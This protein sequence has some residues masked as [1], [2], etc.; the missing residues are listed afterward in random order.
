M[1][2]TKDKFFIIGKRGRIN[3][4]V[5][6]LREFINIF[7]NIKSIINN[8]QVNKKEIF[9]LNIENLNDENVLF[10]EIINSKSDLLKK[11]SKINKKIYENIIKLFDIYDRLNLIIEWINEI[12]KENY[13]LPLNVYEIKI[14]YHK[15]LNLISDN[16]Y[17]EKNLFDKEKKERII[18]NISVILDNIRSPYNVGSIIRSSEA[19]G[20]KIVALTGITPTLENNKVKR[21]S[22]GSEI[23][24]IYFEK[25]EEGIKYFKKNGFNIVC[26]EKTANAIHF[27]E[28]KIEN[29]CFIFG[30][31]EFGISPDILSYADK[32]IYIPMYGKKNSLNVS[33]AAGIILCDNF[34]KFKNLKS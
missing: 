22:M 15:I 28:L 19:F 9:N 12:D 1:S 11:E 31:E 8:N 7:E 10:L 32:I 34:E 24:T 30:N 29:P 4:L 25:T 13:N 26:V 17:N 27:R 14:F 23:E 2:F 18:Y 6:Y 33:V 5:F 16:F 20:V 21:V 3:K